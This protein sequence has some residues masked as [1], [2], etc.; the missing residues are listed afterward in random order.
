MEIGLLGDG[1]TEYYKN[2]ICYDLETYPDT[3]TFAAVFASGKGMRVYEI[4]DRKND[5]EEMLEFMR[6]IATGGYRM[7]GFNNLGFDYPVLHY[8]LEKSKAARKEGKTLQIT[9]SEIYSK[10]CKMFEQMKFNKFGTAVRSD[11]VML[12]QVDLFKIKHFDNHA[13]STSLKMLEFNMRSKNIEDLPFPVGMRLNDEQRDVLIEY[14][15]HDVMETL[16]FYY[17]IFD[18]V[19]MRHELSGQF[20]FDCTNFNDTK[21]GKELFVNRL[22]SAKPG[23]CYKIEKKGPRMVRQMQ[24]T[25]RSSI[26]LGECVLPYVQFN[27]PEFKAIHQWFLNKTIVETKGSLTDIEEHELGDVAKYAKLRVKMKKMNCPIDG[28]KNKRYVPTEE[29]ILEMMKEHPLGWVEAVE[30]KSPKGAASY[31]FCWNIAETLNVVIN[32]FQYDYGT[33]GIHGAKQGVHSSNDEYQIYSYDIASMY[34]NVSIQNK[35]FPEHLDILFC[36]VYEGLYRERKSY[37]KKDSRNKALKLALNGTYGAS[38]DQYSPM[39]D[40]KFTMSITVNG[41]LLLSMLIDDMIEQLGADVL[42]CNTDGFEFIAKKSD[43]DMVAQIVKSWEN[44][45]KLEME[46]ELYKKML[47]RDVNNYLAIKQK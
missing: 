4:S 5:T 34:P 41:Q 12:K 11:E 27:R 22:E 35:L 3:F 25:K 26:N 6:N 20:G 36:S 2:D 8:I 45:T 1:K 46:G 24:Q 31:W 28:A 43:A 47:I 7:V 42:M 19:K 15:K 9:A 29:Q 33:G 44:V 40:P 16:K 39:Y 38:N 18:E 17:R 10:V 21:I 23:C 14:N 13:K 32:G 37:D 30:L